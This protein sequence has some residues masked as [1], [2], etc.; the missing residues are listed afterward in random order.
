MLDDY[1]LFRDSLVEVMK[2]APYSLA[3]DGSNDNGLKKMNPLTV[4]IYDV[5]LKRVKTSLLDMCLSSG[6]TAEKL[7]QGINDCLAG[8]RIPWENCVAFSVDNT[9]VNMG[10]NNSILTRVKQQNPSV[11]FNGCQCH[12]VHN[13][14]AAAAKAFNAVIG[15]DVE[16]LLVDIYHW[17][18]Y[19]T[20]RKCKLAEY[21]E[22]C[23]QEY[24]KILK[25]VSTRWLSLEK[26]VTRTLLQ[27]QSLKTYFLSENDSAARFKRLHTAFS[28]P[29]TEV[30]LLFYQS[31]LQIFINLNLFLQREEPLIGAINSSL[32]RFLKLLA[33]KFISPVTVKASTSF[34]QLLDVEQYLPGMCVFLKSNLKKKPF[35]TKTCCTAQGMCVI[36]IL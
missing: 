14:S 8:H 2:N 5:N 11:Y 6:S 15:F 30:Y 23:D 32:K 19:S 26:V 27:Y 20:K 28:N 24:R 4:Q 31:A 3:T 21:A 35:I 22:F 9:N 7:F 36:N 25:H 10:K 12:V 16:D 29:M 13:T 17:F 18:L 34:Q 33:C 1:F